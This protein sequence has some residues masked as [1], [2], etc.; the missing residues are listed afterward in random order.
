MSPRNI[1]LFD[2]RDGDSLFATPILALF[3]KNPLPELLQKALK[4]DDDR[5]EAVVTALV[6]ENRIDACHE[7][8]LPRYKQL[9]DNFGFLAKIRLMEALNFVPQ[10]LLTSAD[11]IRRVRNKFA[12]RLDIEQFDTLPAE[13]K[14]EL[15]RIHSNFRP[16]IILKE[17]QSLRSRFK[18]LASLTIAGLDAYSQNIATLRAHISDVKVIADLYKQVEEETN[19]KLRSLLE[20][21]PESVEY[22]DGLKIERFANGVVNVRNAEPGEGPEDN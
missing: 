16:G 21:K 22:R 10:H 12:H 1:G 19:S 11:L 2:R 7:A 17:E 3:R 13:L 4:V 8:F 18:Q 14:T 20:T 9:G 5:F 15:I 6:V